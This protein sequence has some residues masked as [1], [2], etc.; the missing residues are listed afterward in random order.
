MSK[1]IGILSVFL[2]VSACKNSEI[3]LKPEQKPNVLI[4]LTDDMGYGDR[5]SYGQSNYQTPHID[6]IA[7]HGV[8]S[9]DFYVPTPYCAPSRTTLLT[10]R[11]PLRHGLIKNPHPDGSEEANNVGISSEEILMSEVFREAGYA[12]KMVGKWHMGHKKEFFPVEHG[13]DEYYGILYSNDMRPVQ[14]IQDR[15]TVQYPVDQRFLTKDYTEKAIEFIKRKKDDPFFL[16]LAHAMPHK[17]LAA[18]TG[19]IRPTLRRI[20]MQM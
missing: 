19:S 16:Y 6:K 7:A 12:T 9:T 1:L 13:F 5:S 3:A 18:R 17:P 14:I 2:L 20:C 15:D 4:I 8:K 11:F 10:G